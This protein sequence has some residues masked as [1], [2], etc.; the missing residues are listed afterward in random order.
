MI[1][2]SDHFK[3]LLNLRFIRF[4]AVGIVNTIFGYSVYAL[5]LFLNMH[6][7]L[8]SFFSTVLGILFNFKTIG[9]L[10]FKSHDNSL[11]GRFF[12]TYAIVYL[13]N[14]LFLRISSQFHI[15][16][17]LAGAVLTVPM[18][19]ISYILNKKFVFGVKK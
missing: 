4:L 2:I 15:D 10:V 11:I 5:F 6:Y 17:Y 19:I 1:S 14:L 7:A 9:T 12:L 8:A 16:L 3:Q 18:A 13:L